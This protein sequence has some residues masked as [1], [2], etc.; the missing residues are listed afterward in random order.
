MRY[1]KVI[2]ENRQS[3]GDAGRNLFLMNQGQELG[4]FWKLAMGYCQ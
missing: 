2:L 1:L 4:A 3:S